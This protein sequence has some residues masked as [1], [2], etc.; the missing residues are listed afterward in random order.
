MANKIYSINEILLDLNKGLLSTEW[1]VVPGIYSLPVAKIV[2]DFIGP[3][4]GAIVLK[5]FVNV[6]TGEFRTFVAK[7]LKDEPE[8]QQLP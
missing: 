2:N 6:K 7:V 3:G 5:A 4:T 1:Q 8:T